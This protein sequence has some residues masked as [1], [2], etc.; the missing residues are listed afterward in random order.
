MSI[1]MFDGL[2]KVTGQKIYARDFSAGDMEGWPGETHWVLVVRAKY[3]DR[4]FQSINRGVIP[5]SCAPYRVITADCLQRDFIN[6]N[7]EGLIPALR[8]FVKYLLL[9][10]G[11]IAQYYGH[12][13]SLLIFD[14]SVGFYNCKYWLRCN[15]NYDKLITFG[16]PAPARACMPDIPCENLDSEVFKGLMGSDI[17]YNDLYYI[18]IAGDPDDEFS[19]V[20]YGDCDPSKTGPDIPEPQRSINIKAAKSVAKIERLIGTPEWTILARSF[21]SQIQDPAFLEPESALCWWDGSKR[22]IHLVVG[23]QSPYKEINNI[24]ALF[25]NQNCPFNSPVVKLTPCFLGGGF[26]GRDDS[27]IAVYTAIAAIYAKAPVRLENDRSEQFISGIKRHGAY[28]YNR[29]V[30]DDS[31]NIQVLT[32]QAMLDGGGAAN[33]TA[34]VVGLAALHSGGAYRIPYTFMS[35]YGAISKNS[36]AGSMRGFGIPQVTFAVE[37]MFDEMAENLKKDPI[38]LRLNQVLQKGDKNLTGMILEHDLKNLEVCKLAL[39]EALWVNRNADKKKLSTDTRKY[40][41]GFACCMEAFGTSQDG[42]L[43]DVGYTDD[44]SVTIFTDAVEMGQGTL[45]SLAAATEPI[46]GMAASHVEMGQ[47]TYF[48]VLQLIVGGHPQPENP[49]WTP[50]LSGST[51]ASKTAFYQLHAIETACSI[52][53]ANG[54]E[55]TVKRIWGEAPSGLSWKNGELTADGRRSISRSEMI[56]TMKDEGLVTRAMVHTYFR[57]VYA[58]ADYTINGHTAHY[59]IDA[60]AVVT[61]SG[62]VYTVI[63]RENVTYPP[64]ETE[65]YR[66]TLYASVGHLV[67]IEVDTATGAIKVLNAVNIIDPGKVHNQKILEGQVEGGFVMGLGMALSEELPSGFGKEPEGWNFSNYFVPRIKDVPIANMRT[68]I[69]P[70]DG[71]KVLSSGPDIYKKGIG[72]ATMSAVPPA[73]ANAVAHATGVRPNHLPIKLKCQ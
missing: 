46:L 37:S 21:V 27:N 62:S 53:F 9:K 18:R 60:C 67:A 24:V 69:V 40:G 64:E 38:E 35:Y 17:F 34:P 3:A 29:L 61:G 73:I 50:V 7:K 31:G 57:N 5:G 20:K 22:S 2:Q 15:E 10:T 11:E 51:S 33:L 28:L 30:H 63:N 26:G 55:P 4:V 52:L 70:F 47:T 49:R 68:I 59:P 58:E 48:D 72:E 42:V 32:S 25:G 71:D 45:T 39:K 23:T 13:I 56:R 41:V 36:P 43:A 8:L 1:N 54:I 12:P 44:G 65:R 6:M 66:R 19:Y 16:A 14:T